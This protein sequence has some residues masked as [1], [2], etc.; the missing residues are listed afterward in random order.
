MRRRKPLSREEEEVKE[1]LRRRSLQVST[2]CLHG[3]A[4]ILLAFYAT[5]YLPPLAVRFSVG[6]GSPAVSQYLVGYLALGILCLLLGVAFGV[7]YGA[8][9]YRSRYHWRWYVFPV[10]VA[11]VL[12]PVQGSNELFSRLVEALCLL[13]GIRFGALAGRLRFRRRRRQPGPGR[14]PA[15]SR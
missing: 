5:D 9:I 11:V 14:G 13:V 1:D 7:F 12:I 3:M 6:L 10:L 2:F 8:R 4:W 15:V